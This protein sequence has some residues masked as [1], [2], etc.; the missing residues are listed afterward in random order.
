LH[1]LNAFSYK[2]AASKT[3]KFQ[4]REKSSESEEEPPIQKKTK[5][6]A[7][8]ERPYLALREMILN[9]ASDLEMSQSSEPKK[10]RL[11]KGCDN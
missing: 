8:P 9:G 6:K 4:R 7:P 11:K 5:E 10:R 2:P 3:Q 1:N